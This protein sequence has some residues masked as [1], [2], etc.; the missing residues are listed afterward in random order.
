MKKVFLYVS[1]LLTGFLTVFVSCKKNGDDATGSGPAITP[2][3]D[4]YLCTIGS[5]VSSTDTLVFDITQANLGRGMVLYVP[6]NIKPESQVTL[7]AQGSSDLM[8]IKLKKPYGSRPQTHFFI[9]PD[10]SSFPVNPYYFGVSYEGHDV[11]ELQFIIKRSSTDNKKFTIESKKYPGNYLNIAK[12][13]VTISTGAS[14]LVY[15][16]AKREFFFMPN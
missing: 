2:V 4:G 8:L 13:E 11:S 6:G 3:I 9:S 7:I 1:M 15:T 5:Y 10:P 16:A 12:P 14:K